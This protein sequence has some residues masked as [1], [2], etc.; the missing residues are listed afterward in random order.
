[1]KDGNSFLF[2]P[3]NEQYEA[4]H[5]N[6]K[7]LLYAFYISIGG[8]KYKKRSTFVLKIIVPTCDGQRNLKLTHVNPFG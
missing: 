5:N 6:V 7:H 4:S 2:S 3:I 8:Q 1:M